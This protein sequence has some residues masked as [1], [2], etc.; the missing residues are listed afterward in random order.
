MSKLAIVRGNCFRE[1]VLERY[2]PIEDELEVKY[3]STPRQKAG[4]AVA[5]NTYHNLLLRAI[6]LHYYQPGLP[7]H[8]D[9]FK[10]NLVN[11]IELYNYFTYASVKWARKHDKKS[12]VFCWETLPN[13]PVFH[14]TIGRR[15][16]TKYV[17]ENADAFQVMTKRS[18]Y[19]LLNLGVNEDLIITHNY[20]VD[21][22]RFKPRTNKK[23]RKE[24]GLKRKTALFIGRLTS[25]KGVVQLIKAFKQLRD[26]DLL[27]IGD[28]DLRGYVEKE[29]GGNIHYA[30]RIPFKEVH[31]YFNCADILCLPSIPHP[32]WEEQFG[33]VLAQAMS[34]GLPVITTRSGAIPEVVS[35]DEGRL[36]TPGSVNEL[37]GG[38]EELLGD[39]K[40]RKR[41]SRR[42]RQRALRDYD[43]VKNNHELLKK[44][45]A[46]GLIP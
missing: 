34:S 30:G 29:A 9:L 4:K 14:K 42:A 16:I 10:P 12:V 1:L 22:K 2:G 6:G 33:E 11:S 24:L 3:Y 21:T 26:Y 44:Y 7:R 41:L 40:L 36:V 17:V 13:H 27:M 5:V 8:L 37:V 38:V 31:Q 46:N 23:L 39:D 18:K 35:S 25:E 43:N 15:L 28:G 20:G 45:Q 19:C 32:L